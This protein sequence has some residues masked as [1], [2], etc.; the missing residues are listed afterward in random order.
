MGKVKTED[1][2]ESRALGVIKT[3]KVLSMEMSN[4]RE[5]IS[6][7][8]E[9]LNVNFKGDNPSFENVK[10]NISELETYS[11]KVSMISD[12]IDKYLLRLGTYLT[13]L[14]DVGRTLNVES[15]EDKG[16]LSYAK[17]YTKDKNVCI[18]GELENKMIIL[19]DDHYNAIEQEIVKLKQD[20]QY[21]RRYYENAEK[22]A[23]KK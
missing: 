12:D 10:E 22:I 3:I 5:P 4:Y 11:R 1:L 18:F 14:E 21:L 16:I 17:D 15:E 19:D 6:K 8:K 23:I 13:V 2:V 7:H 20:D 9:A